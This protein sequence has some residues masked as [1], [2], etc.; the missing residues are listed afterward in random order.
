MKLVDSWL[1]DKPGLVWNVNCACANKIMIGISSPWAI[2][3][4]TFFVKGCL[5]F[6]IVSAYPL[7]MIRRSQFIVVPF[8]AQIDKNAMERLSQREDSNARYSWS[9]WTEH[10]LHFR[11]SPSA[12]VQTYRAN[13]FFT[14]TQ[15]YS[16]FILVG[17]TNWACYH[18]FRM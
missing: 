12:G 18:T 11:F 4:E 2:K 6:V 7:K 15:Y 8:W 9:F 10:I 13:Y 5:L 16:K 3:T 14:P 17:R 1:P